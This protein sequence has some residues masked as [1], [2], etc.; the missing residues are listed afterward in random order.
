M[1]TNQNE[2]SM[3]VK[4][5]K[6]LNNYQTTNIADAGI[7]LIEASAEIIIRS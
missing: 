2:E 1:P 7:Q 6:Y 4:Q 5:S 3:T